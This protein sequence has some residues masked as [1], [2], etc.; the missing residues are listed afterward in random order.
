M[1]KAGAVL[2]KIPDRRQSETLLTIDER[3]WKSQETVFSIANRATNNN[4]KLFLSI[5]DLRSSIVLT[6]L[7][8]AYP[9]W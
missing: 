5:F 2:I 1:H 4:R 6:F 9:M 7:I 3:G 8:A